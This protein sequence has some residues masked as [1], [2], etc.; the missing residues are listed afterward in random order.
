MRPKQLGSKWTVACIGGQPSKRPQEL[1]KRR[2]LG[3]E[4]KQKKQTNK[5]LPLFTESGMYISCLVY[6]LFHLIGGHHFPL[7]GLW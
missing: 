3:K 5:N 7:P 2:V 6:I 1:R 4:V